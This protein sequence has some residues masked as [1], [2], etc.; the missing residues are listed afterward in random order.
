MWKHIQ[1][2]LLVTVVTLIIW[3]FAE[4]ESLRSTEVR[5]VEIVVQPVSGSAYTV[6]LQD[7]PAVHNNT[8]RAD[9]TIDGPAAALARLNPGRK[10]TITG[11]RL[12]PAAGLA[13]IPR[14]R[15]VEPTTVDIS[16]TL[17][18]KTATIKIASVPVHV[19]IAPS[20]LNK[21]DIEIPEQDRFL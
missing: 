19:R 20:E 10:E 11:V 4:A 12:A 5:S 2:G 21:W 1:T 17:R 7:S 13:A 8:V 18:S 3:V 16:L 14:L 15:I 9:I 6:E